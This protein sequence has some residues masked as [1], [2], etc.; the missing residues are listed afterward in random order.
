MRFIKLFVILAVSVVGLASCSV[1]SHNAYKPDAVQ[2]N[3]SMDDLEKLGEVEISVEYRTYLGFIRAIDTINGI[4]YDGKVHRSVAVPSYLAGMVTA[5]LDRA[6]YKVFEE[7][8]DA[9]Y[10]VISNAT[11]QKEVLFLGGESVAKAKVKVYKFK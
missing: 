5:P 10:L 8:P 2:L 3:L 1:V 11:R 6:L 7:Y 9:E 4:P